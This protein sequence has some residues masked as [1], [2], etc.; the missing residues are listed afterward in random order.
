M[1]HCNTIQE[2]YKKA[3]HVE[4]MLRWSHMQPSKFQEGKFQQRTRALVVETHFARED[5]PT[6]VI[7]RLLITNEMEEEE[8]RQTKIFPTR[9]KCE[10][11]LTK[12][13]IDNGSAINFVG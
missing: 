11:R 13:V 3:I 10:D 4:H 2:A 5:N 7:R 8:W 1:N 9:V 6:L 12:L